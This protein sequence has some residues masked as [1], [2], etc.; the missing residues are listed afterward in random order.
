MQRRA[1]LPSKTQK[2]LLAV[3]VVCMT[4][5]VSNSPAIA[6]EVISQDGETTFWLWHFLGRLHPMVVHFPI[7]FLIFAAIL[8]IFTF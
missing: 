2:F 3:L 7:A 8:E 5:V 4:F 1:L 6:Q